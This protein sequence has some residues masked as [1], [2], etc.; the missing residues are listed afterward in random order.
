VNAQ[1]HVL[2]WEDED[3]EALLKGSLAYDDAIEIRSTV[4]IQDEDVTL[5][6]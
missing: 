4:S 3:V 2:F 6:C 5:F 1:E